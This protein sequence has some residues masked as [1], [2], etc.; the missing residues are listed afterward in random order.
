MSKKIYYFD[1]ASTTPPTSDVR[2]DIDT[3]LREYWYNPS[4]NY[5]QG[6]KVKVAI[7][8]AREQIADYVGGGFAPDEIHFCSTGSESDNLA[9]QGYFKANKDCKVLITTPY[10]HSALHKLIPYLKEQGIEVKIIPVDKNGIIDLEKYHNIVN[11]YNDHY[12]KVLVSVMLA[13]NETG[14]INPVALLGEDIK[15]P[16]LVTIHTDISQFISHGCTEEHLNGVDMFSFTGHKLNVPRGVAVLGARNS[17]KIE[18]LI[19]GGQQEGGLIPGTENQAF[20]MALGN[21]CERLKKKGREKQDEERFYRHIFIKKMGFELKDCDVQMDCN[22]DL[23]K[24]VPD[25]L[26]VRFEGLDNNTLLS[27]LT[28]HGVLCSKASACESF[29]KQR[30][31]TLKAIGLTDEQVDSSLRF[32]FSDLNSLDEV[33]EGAKIVAKAVKTLTE[34]R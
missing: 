6:R 27:V 30:S 24:T 29:S 20:I 10:E 9:I 3:F 34:M 16:Q 21:Q 19:Y 32:S 12:E 26:S 5:E 18:P 14:S 25:I 23:S 22:V 2:L 7:N 8:R 15:H 1:N 31:Y 4:S 33:I 28:E 17:V 11:A 13:N